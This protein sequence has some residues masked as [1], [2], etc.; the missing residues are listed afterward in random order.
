MCINDHQRTYDFVCTARMIHLTG[1]VGGMFVLLCVS[2]CEYYFCVN[3]GLS[4]HFCHRG[5]PTKHVRQASGFHKLLKFEKCWTNL[6]IF[7]VEVASLVSMCAHVC[8]S[9]QT[10]SYPGSNFRGQHADAQWCY[11]SFGRPGMRAICC[12]SQ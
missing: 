2:C 7:D 1:K 11:P 8:T 12:K 10:N 6:K 3:V 5:F 4:A 9:L